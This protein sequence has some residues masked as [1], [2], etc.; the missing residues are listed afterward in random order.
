MGQ[1]REGVQEQ[2]AEVTSEEEQEQDAL[3]HHG[4]GLH[5]GKEQDATLTIP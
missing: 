1:D 4:R 5:R 3:H 2:E